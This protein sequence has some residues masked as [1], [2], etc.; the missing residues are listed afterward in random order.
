M[1]RFYD[2]YVAQESVQDN[3][4]SPNFIV[5][6]CSLDS[7]GRDLVNVVLEKE[8][9]RCSTSNTIEIRTAARGDGDPRTEQ[10]TKEKAQQILDAEL[11]NDMY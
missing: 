7:F 2:A 1:D 10:I 8:Y 6:Y 4:I 5:K 11:D 3:I 9:S